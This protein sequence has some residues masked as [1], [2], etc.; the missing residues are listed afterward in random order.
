MGVSVLDV[1]MHVRI[2]LLTKEDAFAPGAGRT[3]AAALLVGGPL[4]PPGRSLKGPSSQV[5]LPH[6]RPLC[7]RAAVAPLLR[8]G[9][10]GAGVGCGEARWA[11]C[12]RKVAV[13][14][15]PKDSLKNGV[16]SVVP[17]KRLPCE[18]ATKGSACPVGTTAKPLA[19][20]SRGVKR[21]AGTAV[22]VATIERPGRRLSPKVTEGF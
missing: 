13:Q 10:R 22:P 18:R 17:Q 2:F 12:V 19:T 1:G 4:P 8:C 3:E 14:E 11:S 20:R 16:V 6:A 9:P 5:D 21:A 15:S 7:G